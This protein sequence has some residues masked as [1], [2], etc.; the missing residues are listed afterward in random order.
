MFSDGLAFDLKTGTLKQGA[1]TDRISKSTAYGDQ[2]LTHANGLCDLID[3]AT[4]KNV[5]QF[6]KKVVC[7]VKQANVTKYLKH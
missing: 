1:A 3:R 6:G 5:A 4:H 7:N 2:A